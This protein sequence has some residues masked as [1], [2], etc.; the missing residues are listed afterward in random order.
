MQTIR[1]VIIDDERY[2]C[3]RLKKLLIPYSKI[4]VT[5]IFTD[6][7]SGL[8]YILEE[9]PD[10]VFLDIEME[11]GASAFDIIGS[12]DRCVK[13]PYII[14]VTGHPQYSIK[15]IKHEVF[16]YLIKPV[17]IDELEATINRLLKHFMPVAQ[18]IMGKY[19]ML[20]DR[21][22]KVLNHVMEGKSSKEIASLLFI[23]KNTVNTHRR[24]ILKKTG[25]RSFFDLL[26]TP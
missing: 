25:A 22:L 17:D 6:S 7:G 4:Q 8:K 9:K 20:S 23:S 2:A 24:N 21:E 10:L 12:L 3:E 26:R 14:I 5:N 18:T 19:D 16:D 11:K 1:A 13:R 15:A